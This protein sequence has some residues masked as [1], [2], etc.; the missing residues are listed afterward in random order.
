MYS[1]FFELI[2]KGFVVDEIG[3]FLNVAIEA[4]TY[5]IMQL[6]GICTTRSYA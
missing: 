5:G 1:S 2:G 6:S 3:E 4:S